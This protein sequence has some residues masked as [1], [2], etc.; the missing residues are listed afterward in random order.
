MYR[1][2]GSGEKTDPA[3]DRSLHLNDAEFRDRIST[4]E[5]FKSEHKNRPG[6]LSL[7]QVNHAVDKQTILEHTRRVLLH[8]RTENFRDIKLEGTTV[9]LPELMR[10][11]SLYHDFDKAPSPE[12]K[13]PQGKRRGFDNAVREVRTVNPDFLKTEADEKVFRMLLQ[14]SDFFGYN[15]A[16]LNQIGDTKRQALRTILETKLEQPLEQ[17]EKEGID[18]DWED[19]LRIQYELSRA[20]TMGI[21][22]FKENVS[23]IDQLYEELV[24]AL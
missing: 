3:R 11:V 1:H 9:N 10:M 6:I 7:E 23:L 18:L 8:L 4:I 12:D 24:K 19:V 20:D 22:T 2:E 21:D 16:V 15:L 17:L 14:T 5:S 13:S